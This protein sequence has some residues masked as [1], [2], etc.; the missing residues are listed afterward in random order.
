LLAFEISDSKVISIVY[1]AS[2]EIKGDKYNWVFVNFEA[3]IPALRG[4]AARVAFKLYT[5]FVI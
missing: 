4:Q 3:E 5:Q 2:T 1:N